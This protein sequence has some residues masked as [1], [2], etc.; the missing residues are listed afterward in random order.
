MQEIDRHLSSASR[1]YERI[2]VAIRYLEE[3]FQLQPNLDDVAAA[4]GLSP[5]HFHRLFSRWVGTTPKRFLQYLTVEYAKD[6]L[7][8]S[9]SVME[10]AWDAGLSGGS[11]LHDLMVTIEAITP[12][13]Y[14]QGGADLQVRWA[15]HPSPFGECVIGVTDRGLCALEFLT[16]RSLAEIEEELT[17][18]WPGA[19][20]EEDPSGTAPYLEKLF[21]EPGAGPRGPFTLLI[22]GT[23]F[24]LQVWQ[25]LLQIPP[26][27]LTEPHLLS[28]PVPPGD[29]IGGWARRLPLGP[30]PQAGHAGLGS[31][32]DSS[33]RARDVVAVL[34]IASELMHLD[35]TE[36][37]LVEH[38]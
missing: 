35:R 18:R 2:E 11:R 9:T 20:L 31:H 27:F 10:A 15:V 19:D 36:P 5:H 22:M 14:K 29:S 38:R 23:N 6:R 8:E 25:A 24:Q 37:S 1:D 4:T 7:R 26:G 34:D 13:E 28:D 16:A 33:G 17:R 12:G 3:N 32:R 21:P 30:A